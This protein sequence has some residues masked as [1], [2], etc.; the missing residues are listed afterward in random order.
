MRLLLVAVVIGG[1]LAALTEAQQNVPDRPKPKPVPIAQRWNGKIADETLR[2]HEPPGGLVLDSAAWER[3]WKAWRGQE[4][5]PALDFQTHL[6]LVFT[7]GG[8]NSVGCQPTIDAKGNVRAVAMSTLIGGPGFGYLMLCI[9]REGVK[10]VN[11]RALDGS[12]P[13][14]KP[15]RKRPGGGEPGAVPGSPGSAPPGAAGEEPGSE[16][17]QA[18]PTRPPS[19]QPAPDPGVTVESPPAAAV[20]AIT[21]LRGIVP[22][23]TAFGNVKKPHVLGSQKEAA[24]VLEEAEL[25]KLKQQ[26]DFSKQFVLLF[27][28]HGSGQDSLEHAV[29]ES[30][31]EQVFFTYK[32]GRTKDLR[33]HVR[34]YA[35]R[36]NVTWEVR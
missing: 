26:V 21:R 3:L 2:K 4:K 29:A 18:P 20:P 5:L 14:A 25:A 16:P 27:A 36:S 23:R 13:P 12:A 8:P 33:Q 22:R 35:L 1:M 15:P 17:G 31:P 6:V 30:Y 10:A 11:G 28:W 34:I 9:S 19:T 24:E 7:A 32:P